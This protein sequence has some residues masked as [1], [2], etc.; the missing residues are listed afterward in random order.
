MMWP[1]TLVKI[2]N[3]PTSSRRTAS[4]QFHYAEERGA[5][6]RQMK[7]T[8]A[9]DGSG[10]EKGG[11][12]RC[13]LAFFSCISYCFRIAHF[14]V[15]LVFYDR[16]DVAAYYLNEQKRA[17][18]GKDSK[19]EVKQHGVFLS[20]YIA[21]AA[22]TFTEMVMAMAMVRPASFALHDPWRFDSRDTWSF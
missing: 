2:A 7:S 14:S 1:R 12:D 19:Q 17:S 13:A 22:S 20:Q 8:R 3:V 6:R 21:E 10:G 11:R 5:R 16:A 15:V 9:R 18:E 4:G